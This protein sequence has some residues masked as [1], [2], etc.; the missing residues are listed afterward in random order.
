MKPLPNDTPTAPQ[1]CLT[2]QLLNFVPASP[3]NTKPLPAQNR[4]FRQLTFS[5]AHARAQ[6]L[7]AVHPRHAVS[8]TTPA[9][10]R[11]GTPRSLQKLPVIAQMAHRAACTSTLTILHSA[12]KHKTLHCSI[13]RQAYRQ[14]CT[15][16]LTPTPPS[17]LPYQI[18]APL[19]G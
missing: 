1:T 11:Q 3:S 4:S 10:H 18:S 16:P 6:S 15:P 2:L 7:P 8:A 13:S 5:R 19:H 17:F 9:A 12:L 14:S